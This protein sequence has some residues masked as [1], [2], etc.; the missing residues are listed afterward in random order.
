MIYK[1]YGAVP[2]AA[3]T[4][5]IASL[6]IQVDGEIVGVHMNITAAG[7][8]ALNDSMQVELSFMSSNTFT[9]NDVRGSIFMHSVT[10]QFLTSGGGGGSDSAALAGLMIHVEAGERIH[11][12]GKT[13]AGVSGEANIYIYVLDAT[14][15]QQRPRT[16]RR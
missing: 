8:D 1:M 4:D 9:T 7:M 3:T 12:H 2:I 10:Q 13:N 16:R 11:F 15:T 6:D 5:S 14:A